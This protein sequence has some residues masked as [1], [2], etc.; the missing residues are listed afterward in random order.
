MNLTGKKALVTGVTGGIGR[1]IAIELA[2]DG[3]D[4]ALNYHTNREAAQKLSSEIRSLGRLAH[5]ICADVTVE[6]EVVSMVEESVDMLAGLDILVNNAGVL[7]ITPLIKLK[8]EEW[9]HT[10]NVNL[11][12]PFLCSLHTGRYMIEHGGGTIVNVSSIAALNPEVYMGAYSVSKAALNMLT[13][14]MAV[15]W[16]GY[17][18]R[19]N[20]VCPGPVDTIMI[21]QAFDTPELLEARLDGIPVHRMSRPEEVAKLVAFLS[22]DDSSQITGEHV[23]IDGGSARSMYYLVN[24]LGQR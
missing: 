6:D 12:G 15:E 5:P 23:V 20:A 10:M 2:K 24:K 21:R 16:A 18:V 1:A 9:D 8:S 19:V 7:R 11:R 14:L 13:E 17:G 22:S 4:V 3:A